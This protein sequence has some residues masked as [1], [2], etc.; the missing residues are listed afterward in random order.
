MFAGLCSAFV[1][2]GVDI[3]S[4]SIL[5]LLFRITEKVATPTSVV[6]MAVNTCVGFF[7]RQLIMCDISQLAWEY[8]EV[9]GKLVFLILESFSS[10]RLSSY[11][12]IPQ[13]LTRLVKQS[14]NS[15]KNFQ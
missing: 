14:N 8:F 11:Q 7:W 5:T 15:E 13:P 4:F 2:S 6:L 10:S 12:L 3:C 9:S 1:G